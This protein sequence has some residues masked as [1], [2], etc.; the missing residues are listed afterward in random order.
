MARPIAA[1]CTGAAATSTGSTKARGAGRPRPVGRPRRRSDVRRT[2]LGVAEF[3]GGR[4][5]RTLGPGLFASAVAVRNDTLLVGTLD[6]T[7]AQIPLAARTSR[8][9]RPIVRDAPGVIQRSS[10]PTADCTR[11]A[12]TASTPWTTGRWRRAASSKADPDS[13]RQEYSA[14]AVDTAGRLWSALRSRPRHPRRTPRTRVPRETDH[15][16]CVNRSC[17]TPKD[18]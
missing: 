15:V 7:V 13:D 14:L 12:A 17:T 1:C 18:G 11:S 6:T 9:A 3:G 5:I 2:A 4:F 16:F 10:T 8:G